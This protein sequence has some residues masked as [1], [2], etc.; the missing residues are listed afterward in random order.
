MYVYIYIY[1]YIYKHT[2]AYTCTHKREKP[3]WNVQ[4][5][6]IYISHVCI[7]RICIYTCTYT[8]T[9]THICIYTWIYVYKHTC[10]HKR[11]KP[12]CAYSCT[13]TRDT[14]P[15]VTHKLSPACVCHTWGRGGGGGVFIDVHTQLNSSRHSRFVTCVY[16]KVEEGQKSPMPHAVCAVCLS[17]KQ[18]SIHATEPYTL[19][20]KQH[21][22]R[23]KETHT[24]QKS[25]THKM[26]RPSER[27]FF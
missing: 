8:Y 6:I 12:E 24:A 15:A 17:D 19:H 18:H 23:S 2:Y 20:A 16:G 3:E 4:I 1:T 7:Y 10:T 22:I 5:Y 26:Y 9:Y 14:T 25:P 27:S 11:E 21:C 13:S